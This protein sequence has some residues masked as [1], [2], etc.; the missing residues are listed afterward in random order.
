MNIT[1]DTKIYYIN[2]PSNEDRNKNMQNLLNRFGFTNYQRVNAF[3]TRDL[4]KV[5]KYRKFIDDSAF[6]QLENTN[7]TKLRKYHEELT[8]GS[9]GC[10]LSHLYIYKLMIENNIESAIV[11]EDDLKINLDKNEFWKFINSL[12]IPDD[13]DMYLID[14]CS[15][16][17]KQIINKLSNTSTISRFFCT[18]FYFVTLKG[19]QKLLKYL[20]PIKYQIDSQMSV[21]NVHKII[22]I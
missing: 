18:H 15:A 10:F 14:G 9:I 19:A 11:C 22:K 5:Q 3:D 1:K 13:T 4:S 6:K 12:E 17:N 8:C 21:L 7:I 2:L 20:L 16:E